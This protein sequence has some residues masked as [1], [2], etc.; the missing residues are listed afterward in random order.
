MTSPFEKLLGGRQGDDVLARR[1]VLVPAHILH[2]VH[3][4][5]RG[6]EFDEAAHQLVEL[7]RDRRQRRHA[8]GPG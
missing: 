1:N 6:F 5:N 2:V 4:G 8:A 7:R 3:G